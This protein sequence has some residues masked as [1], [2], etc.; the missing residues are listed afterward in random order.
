MPDDPCDILKAAGVECP[1]VEAWG[2]CRA[3]TAELFG[4][5]IEDMKSD[6]RSGGPALLALA[7]LVVK[8]KSQRDEAC[9]LVDAEFGGDFAADFDHRCPDTPTGM[10]S[11]KKG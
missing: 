9:E 4:W 1:E 10:R 5:S 2:K 11:S 3:A 6:V 8:F 7:R